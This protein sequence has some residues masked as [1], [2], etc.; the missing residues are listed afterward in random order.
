MMYSMVKNENGVWHGE[1]KEFRSLTEAKKYIFENTKADF[2]EAYHKHGEYY[3]LRR[4]TF[5]YLNK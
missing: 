4:R 3:L 1:G 2:I 5:E